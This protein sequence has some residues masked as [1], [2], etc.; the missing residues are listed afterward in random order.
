MK[1]FVT[2][3]LIFMGQLAI[4]CEAKFGSR[5]KSF[6]KSL[7]RNGRGDEDGPERL[8]ARRGARIAPFLLGDYQQNLTCSDDIGIES[9]DLVCNHPRLGSD[10][11]TWACR[12][13]YH[14]ITGMLKSTTVC[15]DPMESFISDDCGCC[16]EECPAPC[17]CPCEVEHGDDTAD[18]V[19][20]ELT[21]VDEDDG[22]TVVQK[23]IPKIFSASLIAS[24]DAATCVTT[25]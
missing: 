9:D 6:F 16:D 23:C 14:P 18:H 24:E 13:T 20:V 1:C 4:M 3:Y 15:L 12:S 19:L 25:C 2:I 8:A 7:R 17:E 11:G 5:F 21:I 22:E 10:N